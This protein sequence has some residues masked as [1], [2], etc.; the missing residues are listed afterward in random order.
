MSR[1]SLRESTSAPLRRHMSGS[2]T[3]RSLSTVCLHWSPS[4]CVGNHGLT[5]SPS[6]V[7]YS[8]DLK[9]VSITYRRQSHTLAEWTGFGCRG[10]SAIVSHRFAGDGM[11]RAYIAVPVVG[12]AL[13]RKALSIKTFVSSSFSLSSTIFWLSEENTTQFAFPSRA[14]PFSGAGCVCKPH[15]AGGCRNHCA[16]S[17]GC[18]KSSRSS[19]R[20][21]RNSSKPSSAPSRTHP[22]R[23]HRL[24][25]TRGCKETVCWARCCAWTLRRPGCST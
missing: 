21:L 11:N 1:R 14:L 24:A 12:T 9:Q 16:R 8:V 6:C 23:P 3:K 25:P 13:V 2:S 4:A 19:L 15:A 22:L 17:A 18:V 10:A 20:R 5:R 7:G